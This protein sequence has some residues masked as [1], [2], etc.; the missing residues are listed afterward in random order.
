MNL[1]FPMRAGWYE[2]RILP[3]RGL[4]PGHRSLARSA[5]RFTPFG[6]FDGQHGPERP[7]SGFSVAGFSTASNHEVAPPAAERHPATGSRTTAD[8]PADGH[9]GRSGRASQSAPHRTSGIPSARAFASR[10]GAW[11]RAGA[12][13]VPTTPPTPS[14]SR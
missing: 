14:G 7:D 6:W 5:S 10:H 13:P 8:K 3:S 2:D 4:S 1:G 9:P 11:R 12:T